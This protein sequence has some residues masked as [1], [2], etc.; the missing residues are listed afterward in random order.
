[1]PNQARG[2]SIPRLVGTLISLAFVLL[3]P[4]AEGATN[5]NTASKALGWL[6]AQRAAHGFPAGIVESPDWSRACDKHITYM[7]KSGKTGHEEDPRSPHY[8]EEGNWGGTHSVLSYGDTWRADM[9]PWE[10]G[11]IHLAQLLSPQISKMGVADRNGFVCATTWPG[12]ERPLPT[13]TSVLTYPGNGTKIY[14]R[15]IAREN[16]FTPGDLLG[17]PQGTVTGPHLYVYVWGP[18]LDESA[19][20]DI[21]IAQAS[22][23]GPQGELALKWVDHTSDRIGSYLPKAS[24]IIIPV[25]P[26]QAGAKFDASVQFS[27]GSTHSWMFETAYLSNE[28]RIVIHRL[29]RGRLTI[30]ASSDAPNA[31]LTFRYKGQLLKV[32]RYGLRVPSTKLARGTRVCLQSGGS[33][34]DYAPKQLCR[35]I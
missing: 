4:A 7:Q 32:R 20:H 21:S 29:R 8:T 24:G 14:A 3:T 19:V 28:L 31:K 2:N 9:N 23:R 22:L 34:T 16:P 6:N 35:T 10:Y 1:M 18:V 12:Y 25:K 17:L 13:T 33:P 15:E 27:D 5:D 30:S 11:P 26:L